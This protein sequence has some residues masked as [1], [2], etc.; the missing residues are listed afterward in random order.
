MFDREKKIFLEQKPDKSRK[1]SIDAPIKELIDLINQK[2]NYYTTSSCS[3]RIMV[4]QKPDVGKKHEAEWL[5]VTHD[6]GVVQEVQTALFD[7]KG[8]IWFKQEP[9]ILH[10]CCR[11]I[12][13]AQQLV[14]IARLVGLK[15]SGVMNARKRIL[16]EIVGPDLME[17]IIVK[18]GKLLFTV[19]SFHVLIDEAN[20]RMDKNEKK[21]HSFREEI[22]KIN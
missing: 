22:Q 6:R 1:N 7:R 8:D 14:D 17:T 4:L 13:S 10:I 9:L 2:K 15:K 16:V 20:K 11:D 5:Y 12:D 19:E 3:G 18:E 21:A